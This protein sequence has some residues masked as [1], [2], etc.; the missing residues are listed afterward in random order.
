MPEVAAVRVLVLLR[1]GDPAAAAQLAQHHELP[2]SQARVHLARGEAAAALAILEPLRQQLE[3]RSWQD[4][5]LIV[6]VLEALALAAH[7][8]EQQALRALGEALTLAE[9]GGFIRLFVDEGEPMRRLLE[10]YRAQRAAR[11]DPL[12]PY[13]DVLLS[14]LMQSLEAGTRSVQTV[15][16]A[17]LERADALIEPLSGRELEILRLI[18]E[19]LSN[20]EIADR[21]YLSLSTVK[22][23]NRQ[24][25]DKLQ[26]QRRTEAIARA[27]AA[28]LL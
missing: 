3:A 10:T 23:H 5:R 12:Q 17:A 6:L 28:G 1:Q 8:A 4:E 14:A 20:Q 26:V 19:G 21:L 11:S 13:C 2:L 25:F 16:R 24:I 15:S 7:G 9:P 18:A 27:R 22:G